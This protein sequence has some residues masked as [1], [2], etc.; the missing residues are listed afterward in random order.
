MENIRKVAKVYRKVS[1]KN[2]PSDFAY[3]QSKSCE[4]RLACLEEIRREYH[5]W[6]DSS[7]QRL[8]RIYTIVKR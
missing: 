5:G 1:I 6:K 7:E 8:Q 2:Q 3:W 4:E